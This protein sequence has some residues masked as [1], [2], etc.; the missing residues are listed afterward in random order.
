MSDDKIE[1]NE[2]IPLEDKEPKRKRSKK[3]SKKSYFHFRGGSTGKEPLLGIDDEPISSYV[4]QNMTYQ[5]RTGRSMKNPQFYAPMH[6]QHRSTEEERLDF[7]GKKDPENRA[8]SAREHESFNQNMNS[9]GMP[10]E[11]YRM[12][13]KQRFPHK[14][15]DTVETNELEESEI[16]NTRDHKYSEIEIDEE[17]EKEEEGDESEGY[18]SFYQRKHLHRSHAHS[19]MDPHLKHSHISN[20][21]SAP[22]EREFR[23]NRQQLELEERE[24]NSRR[25]KKRFQKLK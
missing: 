14:K 3:H 22:H 18:G 8:H 4:P 21:E 12:V 2:F 6:H 19:V 10:Q 23:V 9:Q 16:E 1:S 20:V 5:H 25:W 13:P 15:L 7:T 17:S 11:E 24:R